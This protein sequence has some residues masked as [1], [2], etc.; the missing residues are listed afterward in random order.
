MTAVSARLVA[1]RNHDGAAFRDSFDLALENSKLRRV[2]QV[3]GGIDRQEWCANFF[4]ARAGIVIARGFQRVEDIVGVVGL[5]M[6][7]DKLVEGFVSLFEIGRF[8][9]AQNRI[10]AHEPEHFSRGVETWRLRRIFTAF[11]IRI[12][13]DRVDEDAAPD[14]VPSGN[15]RR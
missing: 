1:Q 8:F 7:G 10:A 5:Q 2:D 15:L 12:V 4:Q 9:L 14:A 13:P 3:V 11:P 6:V